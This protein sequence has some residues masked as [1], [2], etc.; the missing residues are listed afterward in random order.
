M[1]KMIVNLYNVLAFSPLHC[2]NGASVLS[3]NFH[4]FLNFVMIFGDASGLC[5]TLRIL[6]I[7]Y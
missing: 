6:H 1:F 7:L 3:L 4:C 2:V 5:N